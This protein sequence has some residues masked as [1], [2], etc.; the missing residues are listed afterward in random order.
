MDLK[1]LNDHQK[2]ILDQVSIKQCLKSFFKM[3]NGKSN[4]V[5]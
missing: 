2:S 3:A 4:N 1:D 5:L